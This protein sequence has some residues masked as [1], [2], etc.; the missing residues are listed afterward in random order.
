MFK[1]LEGLK[2]W[3]LSTNDASALDVIVGE[4]P[5]E[6]PLSDGAG[7]RLQSGAITGIFALLVFYFLYF[8]SPILISIIMALLLSMLLAPFVGLLDR[9]VRVPRTLGALIVVVA[10]VWSFVWHCGQPQRPRSELAERT[11]AVLPS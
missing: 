6:A 4:T 10:A 1:V 7:A 5:A 3:V 8:A 2:N 9:R 11:A